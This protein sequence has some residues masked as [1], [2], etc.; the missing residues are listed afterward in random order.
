MRKVELRMNELEKYEVIKKL[1]DTKGNKHRAAI[2]LNVTIR[3]INRL[4]KKYKEEGKAGFI[5]GNRGRIPSSAISLDLKKQIIEDYVNNFSD[6]NFKHFSEIVY[7]DYH[8]RIS[9]TTINNWLR[10]LDII[11]PK[12]RKKTKRNLKNKL[13]E[14]A[15]QTNSK[16][17]RN[18]LLESIDTLDRDMAH[19]RRP[20]CKYMGEMI[21]M[22]ASQ[23]YWIKD[24]QWYL[25]LAIDDATSTVV[26]AY[27]D[28][29]ETLNGYYQV[30]YQIL[31]HYGI[32]AMFYTDKRTVFEYKRKNTLF[33]DEDTYTQFS[34]ACHT[35]GVDIK[36]TSVPQAKG[37]IERLNQTFQS[38]LPVE[39]RRAHVSNI[40]E[41]NE[42]LKS[43][44]KKFNDQF[45]LQLNI[46]K[47]VFETQPSKEKI[48]TTLSIMNTRVIDN[49]HGIR[50]KNKYYI[51]TTDKGIK[52]FMKNRTSCIV[53]E[54]FNGNLYLNHLDVLYNLEE[55]ANKE[56]YS[57]QFDPD[58]KEI[59]PKK[60]Y[61]PPLD[62]PW[63]TDNILQ[64]FG[65]QKHR[66]QIGA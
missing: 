11:S 47:S 37:R 29:Q 42:F 34:Y 3:T 6:T 50:Y 15:R 36:T 45:A 48:N 58:Y 17:I 12:A 30:F 41:A 65:S 53:I 13:K 8:I 59:K 26:G 44:L 20:R 10:E 25:H 2:K 54:A 9:D 27:F 57:K 21:Q 31:T 4:I 35:L 5:H 32:P 14:R 49:G 52:V 39:L 56:E 66:Q 19:P 16:K 22:D 18:E 43:Y 38:R 61:I 64:Y 33:D 60:K 40:D 24:Q 1:V 46:T 28:Y 63:R 51:P 23:F 7:E 62:H 55:V